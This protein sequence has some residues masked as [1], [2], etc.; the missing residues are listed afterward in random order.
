MVQHRLRVVRASVLAE[1]DGDLVECRVAG[2]IGI[3]L[4]NGLDSYYVRAKVPNA[5]RPAGSLL[6]LGV[7]RA[8]AWVYGLDVHVK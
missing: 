2:P 4:Q 7:V 1:S 5:A 6:G 3:N 8:G